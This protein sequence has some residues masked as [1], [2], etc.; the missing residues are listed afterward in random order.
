MKSAGPGE[1]LVEGEGHLFVGYGIGMGEKD[2]GVWLSD[3]IGGYP[4]E[5]PRAIRGKTK[6]FAPTARGQID[7]KLLALEIDRK[8]GFDPFCWV[9]R[10]R[11]I[12]GVGGRTADFDLLGEDGLV[13]VVE[14][15][16]ALREEGADSLLDLRSIGTDEAIAERIA[17]SLGLFGSQAIVKLVQKPS[18]PVDSDEQE[19]GDD[20][21]A[22][23]LEQKGLHF[24]MIPQG[25]TGKASQSI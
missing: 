8:K 15:D 21:G 5:I 22:E 9:L 13:I 12:F 25:H 7:G 6:A 20:K 17:G 19:E 1:E 2:S 16:K 3:L 4:I 14:G 24:N 18:R 10:L 23:G 11:G